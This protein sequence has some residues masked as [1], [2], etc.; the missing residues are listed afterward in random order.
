MEDKTQEEVFWR[1]M[2]VDEM[3]YLRQSGSYIP[4]SREE[5]LFRKGERSNGVYIIVSGEVDILDYDNYGSSVHIRTLSS[6]MVLGEIA[7]FCVSPRTATA[8]ARTTGVLFRINDDVIN[9]LVERCPRAM[10]QIFLNVMNLMSTTIRRLTEEVA[11]HRK[12]AE[13][14]LVKEEREL[15]KNRG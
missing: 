6:G 14:K 10:T 15:A 9:G 12:S 8:R 1:D 13:T 3:R 5:I 11:I 2:G 4:F 7:A